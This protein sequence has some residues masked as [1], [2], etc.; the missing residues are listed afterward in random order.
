[1]KPPDIKDVRAAGVLVVF[2]VGVVVLGSYALIERNFQPLG[3]PFGVPHRIPT[4]GRSYLGGEVRLTLEQIQATIN[5]G[6]SPLLFEPQLGQIPLMAPFQG[7][8]VRLDT[9][10]EVCPTAVFLHVG[11]DAYAAYALE[12]GP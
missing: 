11:A 12:G 2:V 10:A 3:G 1:M 9:G 5:P 7:H 6:T 8:T 4:C